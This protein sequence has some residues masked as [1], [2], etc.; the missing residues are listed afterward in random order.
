MIF[1]MSNSA[2]CLSA[3]WT[4]INVDVKKKLTVQ[5]H[6]EAAKGRDSVKLNKEKRLLYKMQPGCELYC[7]N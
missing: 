5:L 2:K 1:W 4:D 6:N 3:E 7:D